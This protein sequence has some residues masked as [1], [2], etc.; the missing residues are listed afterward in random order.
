ML[1]YRR[2]VPFQELSEA[3]VVDY[4]RSVPPLAQRLGGAG[5]S[6]EWSV[7]E[8]GDG[9]INFVYIIQGPGGGICLKQGAPYIRVVK[10]WL[11]S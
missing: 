2:S 10:E 1:A 11:L 4:L 9:N 3:T 8:V 5:S 7:K 6:A